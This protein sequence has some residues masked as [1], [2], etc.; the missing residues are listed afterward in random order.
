MA[1]QY[2]LAAGAGQAP[3]PEGAEAHLTPGW[4]WLVRLAETTNDVVF[5][6]TL[7]PE[8]RFDYISPSV[9]TLVGYTPQEH[10]LNPRLSFTY[11]HPDDHPTLE[12]LFD[13]PHEYAERL[14]IRWIH[15]NGSVVW[16]EA[17]I[18]VVRDNTGRPIAIRGIDRDVTRHQERDLEVESKRR[19]L[20]ALV[21]NSPIGIFVVDSGGAVLVI[22]QEARRILGT[23]AE[24]PRT[25]D[26]Y[27]DFKLSRVDDGSP[28]KPEETPLQRALRFGQRVVAEEIHLARPDG[29][30]TRV[31]VSSGPIRSADGTLIGAVAAIQDLSQWISRDGLRS[32]AISSLVNQIREPI[33]RIRGLL[34]LIIAGHPADDAWYETL[35]LMGRELVELSRLV[36]KITHW[37]SSGFG[38]VHLSP[39]T[40]KLPELVESCLVDFD[41]LGYRQRLSL[42]M[43]G[44]LPLATIDSGKFRQAM[45]ALL[46][47]VAKYTPVEE[48]MSLSVFEDNGSVCFTITGGTGKSDRPQPVD[49]PALLEQ[50]EGQ[51]NLSHGG[52]VLELSL[53]R[54]VIEAHLGRLSVAAGTVD[55][56]VVVDLSIP[57]DGRLQSTEPYREGGSL[58]ARP[59]YGRRVLVASSDIPLIRL[60]RRA[61]SEAGAFVEVCS[62]S[63]DA[64]AHL[65]RDET[66]VSFVSVELIGIE[67]DVLGGEWSNAD[68]LEGAT[69]QTPI[70]WMAALRHS[71]DV[72]L[73]FIVETNGDFILSPPSASEVVA[74]AWRAV[75]RRESRLS[76]PGGGLYEHDGM[77]VDL[78]RRHV[79]IEGRE[80]RLSPTEFRLLEQLVLHAGRPVT[81]MQLLSLVWG[82]NYSEDVQLLH[83]MVRNLRRKLGDGS[84]DP[85]WIV[86]IPYLGYRLGRL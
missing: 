4:D 49:G 26:W 67:G 27:A 34:T 51:A 80:I 40:S 65:R 41:R 64:L 15:K 22:N 60:V 9:E 43:D 50:A 81:H 66:D 71:Q 46:Q 28:F 56:P 79:E 39:R 21:D 84:S 55:E 47:F 77:S 25:L 12:G 68:E 45:G 17:T 8:R 54:A 38:N 16:T 83:S 20:E 36:A 72:S 70:I 14:P 37:T 74:R 48:D 10:Y 58:C 57:A 7:W 42:E 44:Q 32:E 76:P 73:T 52:D 86:N 24:A 78:S 61:L 3:Q 11:V 31:L 2:V 75:N 62:T 82:A 1:D 63:V 29:V 30:A 59:L 5:S 19:S 33:I 85:R 23:T 69:S 6:F 13:S 18:S 35:G 53:A